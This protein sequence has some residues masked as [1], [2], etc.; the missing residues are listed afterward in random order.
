MPLKP[1][2]KRRG[3]VKPLH[4]AFLWHMHQP[5]YLDPFTGQFRLPWVRL[6]ATKSYFDMPALIE[7][8][9][10]IKV[11]FNLVPTLI[12]Q[13]QRY[14]EGATD[15]W[16][17]VSR[18]RADDLSPEEISFLLANFFM[19]N[20][21]TMV[22]PFRR[23]AEL[24]EKRGTHRRYQTVQLTTNELRDLQVWF[25]L[26]W[27]GYTA[28]DRYPELR[29]LRE[30]GQD[31]SEQ[32][33]Q[34]LLTI[35]REVTSQL[36]PLYRR[37]NDGGMAEATTT[38]YYHPIL[39][40]IYDTRSAREALPDIPLPSHMFRYPEDVQAQ[41]EKAVAFHL[42][43]L[44]TA[45]TGMWP[46]EGAVSQAIVASVAQARIEW[47]ASDEEILLRSLPGS[48]RREVLYHPHRVGNEGNEVTMVFR[49]QTLSNQI[50][51]VYSRNPADAAAED[52]L[53]R[54]RTIREAV[55]SLEGDHLVAIILDG[56]NPWEYYP[57]GGEGFL[58]K[59]YTGIARDPGL[60]PIT[61]TEYLRTHPSATRIP[62]L[63][64]GSWVR[65]SFDLWIGKPEENRAWELLSQTRQ[66]LKVHGSAIGSA[67]QAWEDMYAAEGS[68]WFW[69]FDDDNTSSHDPVFDQL[70]RDRLRHVYNLLGKD[71]PA[72]LDEPIINT[73]PQRPIRKPIGLLAPV[74]DGRPTS[75]YEWEAAG[76]YDVHEPG[77]TMHQAETWMRTIYFG[78]DKD[79]L[80]VRFDT[81][82]SLES[83]R[84]RNIAIII[85]FP[86]LTLA[87]VVIP[88]HSGT[89]TLLRE[90][91]EPQEVGR[92][93]A[94]RIVE[95]MIPFDP[96]GISQGQEIRFTIVVREDEMEVERCPRQ[97][98]ISTTAPDED[99]EARNW[100]V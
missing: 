44:G 6:H 24:L 64:A 29:G 4:V 75:Y 15:P 13:L 80:Y 40:L 26:V 21:D 17:E 55:N 30:K 49:D 91:S 47:M 42:K 58:T 93:A 23:Y 57:D 94:D 74:L 20:W 37:L 96:L 36:I 53:G 9:P 59:V 27:F 28:F 1:S 71:P 3:K 10:E 97:G 54:L 31:F 52:L 69:W 41:I 82:H 50:S 68:D 61:L 34:D 95:A 19:A 86:A 45:P 14:G 72:V 56:E 7:R 77:G 65:H 39:P 22:K 83:M 78:F 16:L 35:Q 87:E 92:V 99:F 25:N 12:E 81:T 76:R 11:T 70:F 46:A 8:I 88:L 33:K 5:S 43:T 67:A 85:I 38:P 98:T 84:E 62:H 89:V 32:D 100:Q 79:T 48:N 90:D 2:V 51:F 18:K 66:Y 73:Q 63:C 60:V